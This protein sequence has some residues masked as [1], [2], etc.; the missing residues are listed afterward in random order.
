M[1][2]HVCTDCGYYY[3]PTEGD[4]ENG[5]AAGT[6]F[7]ELPDGW[8]CPACGAPKEQFVDEDEWKAPPE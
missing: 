1:R 3:D 4:Q 6:L 5:I 2:R 8:V 7:S